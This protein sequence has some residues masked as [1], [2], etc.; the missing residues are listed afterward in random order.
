MFRTLNPDQI[1]EKLWC[2]TVSNFNHDMLEHSLELQVKV[3]ESNIES[4][5]TIIFLQISKLELFYENPECAWDYAELTE[6]SVKKQ[7]GFF[8]IECDFWS[9]AKMELVCRKIILNGVEVKG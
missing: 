2:G 4:N 7:N 9:T 8:S 5:Y 6:I 1:V 3:I